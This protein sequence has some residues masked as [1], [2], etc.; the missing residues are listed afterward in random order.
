MIPPSSSNLNKKNSGSGPKLNSVN[1]NASISFKTRFKL[2]RGSPENGV[3]SGLYTSQIK[4]A[5]FPLSEVHGKITQV[6]KSGYNFISDSSIRTNPSIDE[7][8]NIISLSSTFSNWLIGTST[9]LIVPRI[10]E[11]CSL[12]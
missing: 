2:L 9:F 1:P 10:S 6:S 11:N 8:S 12:K 3:P 5:T 7:P 4:R